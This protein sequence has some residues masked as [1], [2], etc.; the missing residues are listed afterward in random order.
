LEAIKRL[1][2][3]TD[4]PD[5]PLAITPLYH[6]MGFFLLNANLARGQTIVFIQNY[7]DEVVF[8]AIQKYKVSSFY[9]LSYGIF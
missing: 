7:K 1:G 9:G 8:D 2:F 3:D 4:K 6:A 5:Y